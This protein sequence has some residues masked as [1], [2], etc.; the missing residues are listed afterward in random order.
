MSKIETLIT[1]KHQSNHQASLSIETKYQLWNFMLKTWNEFIDL[2]DLKGIAEFST[3]FLEFNIEGQRGEKTISLAR[4]TINSDTDSSLD[5]I[6]EDLSSPD[7]KDY[8][9][10]HGIGLNLSR[11]ITS[12][13]DLEEIFLFLLENQNSIKDLLMCDGPTHFPS[14]EGDFEQQFFAIRDYLLDI[15][16]T[17]EMHEDQYSALERIFYFAFYDEIM[18]YERNSEKS[19]LQDGLEFISYELL[20]ESAEPSNFLSRYRQC[21]KAV[22]IT[23]HYGDDDELKELV[24]D[25]IA[26]EIKKS[27]LV[28]LSTINYFNDL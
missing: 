23:K 11:K 16:K 3:A 4:F 27:I 25:M 22:Q 13:G 15:C 12:L 24:A 9:F 5:L 14:P 19:Y 18:K 6:P 1:F 21:I 7:N 28:K 10:W 26:D 8:W 17:K 20:K 2:E